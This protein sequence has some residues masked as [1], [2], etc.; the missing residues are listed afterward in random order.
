MQAH[1]HLLIP[2]IGI[3]LRVPSKAPTEFGLFFLDFLEL[4]RNLP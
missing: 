3:H 1:K 2:L 4:I